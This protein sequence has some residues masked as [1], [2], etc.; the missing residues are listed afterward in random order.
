M[1]HKFSKLTS[2][3]VLDFA[4]WCCMQRP[5]HSLPQ[6]GDQFLQLDVF[7]EV[8]VGPPSPVVLLREGDIWLL[9]GNNK[10]NTWVKIHATVIK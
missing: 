3:P 2:E 9:L 4:L 1:S 7:T 5:T 6:L 8:G 10:V